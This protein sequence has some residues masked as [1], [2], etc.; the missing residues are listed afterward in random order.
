MAWSTCAV[1]VLVFSRRADGSLDSWGC[2]AAAALLAFG[3]AGFAAVL[4]GARASNPRRRLFPFL[5]LEFACV[6][7]ALLLAIGNV[8]AS[9]RERA[10]EKWARE[11]PDYGA[12]YEEPLTLPGPGGYARPNLDMAMKSPAVGKTVRFQT[13]NLGFRRREDTEM[14]KPKGTFRVLFLGDSFVMGYRV[15]TDE[16]FGN[17]LEA[18]LRERLAAGEFAESVERI[19]VLCANTENF[20]G[21][22]NYLYRQAAKLEPDLVVSNVCL[23]NDF[24]QSVWVMGTPPD[25][26]AAEFRVVDGVPEF[27][28]RAEW[29]AI[30]GPRWDWVNA[31]ANRYPQ[32]AFR[33][34]APDPEN[35][36]FA[37]S[38]PWALGRA[39]QRAREAAR[40][41]GGY[42]G[43]NMAP[44][45]DAQALSPLM[46]EETALL[47]K[48]EHRHRLTQVAYD[49]AG[50][51]LAAYG[52]WSRES[53]TPIVVATIPLRYQAV[54]EDRRATFDEGPIKAEM[55]DLTQPNRFVEKTAKDAG[56]EFFDYAPALAA[57]GP[58]A[59]KAF[60]PLGDIHWT[61]TGHATAA[62][63]IEPAI[64]AH[65][66]KRAK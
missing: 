4:L 43:W 66:P 52:R 39:I 8:L 45:R 18:R 65:I 7:I 25:P 59:W 11:T 14:P 51:A 30:G 56:L 3:G 27:A 24:T 47:L 48:P 44:R 40:E 50:M 54:E 33:E 64:A 38:S 22:W 57:L 6:A 61:P 34:G 19:E 32:E 46:F 29:E 2:L 60:M 42:R 21:T 17:V 15:E 5:A 36:Y 37:P 63:A 55:Y 62:E 1:A 20:A 12:A 49:V 53:G 35:R 9:A 13:N 41:A 10:M 23:A 31:P 16:A 28:P 26:P 58:D